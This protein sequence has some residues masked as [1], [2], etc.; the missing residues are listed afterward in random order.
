MKNFQK[1]RQFNILKR[2]GKVFDLEFC[3]ECGDQKDENHM[4]S[5]LCENCLVEWAEENEVY[6]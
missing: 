4:Y 3:E 2:G 1:I 5:R 6:L